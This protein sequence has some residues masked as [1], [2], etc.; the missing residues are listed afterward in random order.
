MKVFF[1]FSFGRRG[2]DGNGGRASL[3]ISCHQ[4]QNDITVL[5]LINHDIK[6]LLVKKH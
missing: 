3:F 2:N 5:L 4:I 1:P 6:I